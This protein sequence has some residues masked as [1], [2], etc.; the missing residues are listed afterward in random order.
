MGRVKS[1]KGRSKLAK[2][3]A[4]LRKKF[5]KK[6]I[7]NNPF[8]V[9]TSLGSSI[10]DQRQKVLVQLGES[11][12]TMKAVEDLVEGDKVIFEKEGID[13]E[14]E[15]EMLDELLS[16]GRKYR[17]AMT[18]LF[19]QTTEGH[20][21]SFRAELLRGIMSRPDEWPE[22]LA[23]D[24][25]FLEAVIDG[26][27]ELSFEL[28]TLVAKT[29]HDRL[30][31]KLDDW[32]RPVTLSHILNSWLKGNVIAP[33]DFKEVFW[34]LGKLSPGLVDLLGSPD[35]EKDYWMYR[36]MRL[37][38]SLRLSNVIRGE[39]STSKE[40]ST[41]KS[42]LDED[43]RRELNEIVEF[44]AEDIDSNHAIASVVRVQPVKATEELETNKLR[45]RKGIATKKPKQMN[46]RIL[47]PI[48]AKKR[49]PV[50]EEIHNDIVNMWRTRL[51]VNL[52]PKHQNAIDAIIYYLVEKFGFED[53]ESKHRMA[54]DLIKKAGV[55]KEFDENLMPDHG[56][57]EL[58]R[59]YADELYLLI[60]NG[61]IDK[62]LKVEEGTAAKV[63]RTYA[64]ILS[65][66]PNVYYYGIKLEH[67]RFQEGLSES[68][69]EI[70]DRELRITNRELE[71][72]GYGNVRKFTTVRAQ[73]NGLIRS[74]N[75]PIEFIKE[76]FDLDKNDLYALFSNTDDR[77]IERVLGELFSPKKANYNLKNKGYLN[78]L[79][80][81]EGYTIFSEEK[82][83]ILKQMGFSEIAEKATQERVWG[84]MQKLIRDKQ[85][86]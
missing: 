12:Y 24:P 56:L 32:T 40:R 41:G 34:A 23:C 27:R 54:L 68:D 1:R 59:S 66:K 76:L 28:E 19:L 16:K 62:W 33:K 60:M 42:Y 21:T 45:L 72:K 83:A 49:L 36:A 85:F 2:K 47:S 4:S 9:V 55:T 52:P 70:I 57:E 13:V 20:T 22:E 65:V 29:I 15:K 30:L 58:G 11:L 14:A 46:I 50:L 51:H 37:S 35:F 10:L 43:A 64:R 80:K 38:I 81:H 77:V 69:I 74:P 86:Q 75:N 39:C 73:F 31:E 53:Y 6:N 8:I 61:T 44:F 82:K 3:K 63:F 78:L 79:K 26:K 18:S 84:R 17:N 25:E 5:K 67:A 7:Q 48:E 71:E